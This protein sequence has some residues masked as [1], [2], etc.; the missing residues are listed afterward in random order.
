[1]QGVLWHEDRASPAYKLRGLC[2]DVN[3]GSGS[4]RRA[5]LGDH[6]AV[7][8]HL[9]LRDP[10]LDDAAAVLWVLLQ[11]DLVQSSLLGGLHA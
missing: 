11:A 10:G 7:D 3:G 4:H 9:A 8:G 6:S 1:M 2:S 5:G